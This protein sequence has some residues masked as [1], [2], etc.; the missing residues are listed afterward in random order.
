MFIFKVN[1]TGRSKNDKIVSE[2]LFVWKGKIDHD[3]GSKGKICTEPN[4]KLAY[5]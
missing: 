3:K 4:W 1:Q 2:N 5:W